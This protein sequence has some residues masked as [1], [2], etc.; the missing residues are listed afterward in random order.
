VQYFPPHC[1]PKHFQLYTSL[2]VKD[3]ISCPH[4]TIFTTGI[5]CIIILIFVD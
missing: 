1:I 3:K 4:E 5:V 2:N